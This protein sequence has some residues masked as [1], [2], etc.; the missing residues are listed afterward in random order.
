MKS[1]LYESW[2]PL[3]HTHTWFIIHG[4]RIWR[5]KIF[6]SHKKEIVSSEEIVS[7]TSTSSIIDEDHNIS[8]IN[9]SLVVI[10]FLIS[11]FKILEAFLNF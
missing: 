2:M 9:A 10:F 8:L 1:K 4:Y 6:F 7:S 5:L 3:W 11:V